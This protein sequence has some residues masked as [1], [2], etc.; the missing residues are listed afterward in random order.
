MAKSRDLSY[1]GVDPFEET[2]GAE[3]AWRQMQISIGHPAHL[4]KYRSRDVPRWPSSVYMA[5]IDGDHTTEGVTTD[6]GIVMP[7]IAKGG[8]IAMHD[9]GRSHLPGV[10]WGAEATLGQS[11]E[12]VLDGVT[13]TLAVWQLV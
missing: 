13:G 8:Y 11:A 9:Y 10:K 7:L 6:C 1:F 5:L 2:Q 12:W 4:M 3:D